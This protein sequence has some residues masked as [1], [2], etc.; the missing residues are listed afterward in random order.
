MTTHLP[1]KSSTRREGHTFRLLTIAAFVAVMFAPSAQ[2]QAPA[3]A[4]AVAAAASPAEMDKLV[5]R[6]A[7]YPDDLVSIILPAST[8][9]L[10][11]VQADRY[12]DKRKKDPKAPLDDKWDDAVKSLLNYPEIVKMMSADLD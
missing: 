1:A 6:I 12:L 2:A 5:D 7:L 4:T 8:N 9:P 10:Q 3:A 11:M